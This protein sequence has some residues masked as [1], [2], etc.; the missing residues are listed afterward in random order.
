MKI[1]ELEYVF[2]F[3]KSKY[4]VARYNIIK[5]E[6]FEFNNLIYYISI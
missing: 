4:I 3:R 2:A 1:M 5:Y 6:N